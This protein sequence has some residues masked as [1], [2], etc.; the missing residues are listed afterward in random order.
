LDVQNAFLHGVL[1][2][3][4]Y[5]H[6]PLGYKDSKHPNYVCKLDKAIYGLKQAPRAWYARLCNKLMQLGFTPSKGD[7]SLFYYNKGKHII[8]V[9]VYVDDIIIASSTPEATSALLKD[10]DKDFALKDLGDLHFFLGIE[11]K[12]SVD[13]LIMS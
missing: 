2:E 11:V 10:L 13:G 8:F 7:T 1:E 6:Q 3:E 4:G 12:R 5:M 9:L